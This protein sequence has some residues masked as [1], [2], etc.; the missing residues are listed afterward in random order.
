MASADAEEPKC[1]I[2]LR[3]HAVAQA[4]TRFPGIEPLAEALRLRDDRHERRP[5]FADLVDQDQALE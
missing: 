3:L 5:S 2:P 1:E 4:A